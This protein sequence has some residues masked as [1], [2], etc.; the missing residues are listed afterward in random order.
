M[1]KSCSIAR[2]TII[3]QDGRRTIV[4]VCLGATFHAFYHVFVQDGRRWST[5]RLV[6]TASRNE[7]LNPVNAHR[8]QP[9]LEAFAKR[10]E[11]FQSTTNPV[12]SEKIQIFKK[13][14][15]RRLLAAAPESLGLTKTRVN[16]SIE[17]FS[18]QRGTPIR[19]RVAETVQS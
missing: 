16:I 2:L 6:R 19:L 17:R 13:K 12:V 8:Q 4:E 15:Y 1:A 3:R 9:G 7:G 10:I 11:I 14:A 5:K 18:P